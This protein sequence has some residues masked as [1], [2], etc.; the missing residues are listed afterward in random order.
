MIDIREPWRFDDYHI[1][2]AVNIPLP[3]LFDDSRLKQ[4]S[5]EKKIIVYG[6]GAG[7]AAQAQFLLSMKG[8]RAWSLRDGIVQWWEQIIT[9]L[10]VRSD[11]PSP[12][13]YREAK[14]LR[15]QF[16][17]AAKP[18]AAGV[19]PSA[20]PPELP[21]AQLAPQKAPPPANKLKLGQGCS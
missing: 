1:P 19:T 20:A 2:T 9:P 17:R 15:E 12:A 3:R 4:L 10:S 11:D 21:L 8:Y 16:L 5:R 14:Q 18:A 7:H 13:G 6:F